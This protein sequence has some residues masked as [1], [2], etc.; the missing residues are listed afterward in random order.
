MKRYAVFLLFICLLPVLSGCGGGPASA[1]AV[2]G[3]GSEDLT[4]TP[5]IEEEQVM[6]ILISVGDK[7]FS[8]SLTDN[9]A[10]K[11]LV[12]MLPMT[13][14]MSELNGNEKYCYLDSSLPTDAGVPSGIEAGDIK[15]FGN[16]CLVLFYESFP[17]SYS[18][19]PLGHI[20]DPEGLAEALGSGGVQVS[21]QKG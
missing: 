14:G 18:Y 12:D 10:A 7:E 21:F 9:G 20:D 11:A 15:L 8:A 19:T 17:T 3:P 1:D 13:L 16:N 2:P 4:Q 6:N 5:D